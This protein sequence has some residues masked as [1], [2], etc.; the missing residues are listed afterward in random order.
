MNETV[1][2]IMPVYNAEKYIA[3]AI[4][5]VLAQSYSNWELLIVDDCSTDL[6]VS[7]VSNYVKKDDRVHLFIQISL[8]DLL[9]SPAI[10]V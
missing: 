9:A 10:S 3:F 2:V 7:L 8:L 1:S 6:S 4:D 5:S